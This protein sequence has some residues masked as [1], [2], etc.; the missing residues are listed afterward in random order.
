MRAEYERYDWKA[1]AAWNDADFYD[2][3]GP[4]KVSRKGYNVTVGHSNTLLYDQPK[5]MT[6]TV[7][8]TAA[9]NLDQ[10]PQFQNVTV[11]VDRLYSAEAELSYTDVRSSL[12]HV[13]DEKGQV[14]S[15]VAHTDYAN[16][17]AFA[18]LF[19]HYDFGLALPSGHSSVWVRTAAGFSPQ[20]AGEPFANFYF[21]GFGNNYVDRGEI[22]R[23]R[24]YYAFPGARLNEIA[25][26]NFVRSLVEWELPPIRFSRAGTPGF[27]LS[28]LR[29]AVFAGGLVTNL[30]RGAPRRTA[31]TTGG[32]V[33]LR[34]TMLSA[35]DLTLSIGG[36]VRMQHG[37][38][39]RREAM[40]SLALLK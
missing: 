1:H 30:D 16:A 22:K 17:A 27:Y 25:G 11:R 14:W 20:A 8:G 5:R 39:A 15:A 19:G 23:Y 12:G 33:D 4:T 35:L 24:E 29:P 3:F 40:V 2:L 26:R 10:L 28:Y 31:T 36:G 21:G 37:A 38:P 34:F 6:L 13:D 9:G 18:R 7:Q 32:Q